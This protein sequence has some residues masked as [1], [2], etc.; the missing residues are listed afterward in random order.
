MVTVNAR[1]REWSARFR[2]DSLASG[3]VA[4]LRDRGDE[5]W[6]G[7]LNLLQRESP[8]YQTSVDT[9]LTKRSKQHCDKI[10]QTIIAIATGRMTKGVDPFD[11]VRKHAQW[12]VRHQV[13]LTRQQRA[14]GPKNWN[15]LNWR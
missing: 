13:R 2:Q 3:V 8:D 12:R 4:G 1:V 5:I 7:A 9:E 10:L 15:C 11:C 6:E 14:Y